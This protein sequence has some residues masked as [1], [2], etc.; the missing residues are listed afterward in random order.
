MAVEAAPAAS[1]TSTPPVP[2][3]AFSVAVTATVPASSPA[4]LLVASVVSVRVVGLGGRIVTVAS[5]AFAS[6]A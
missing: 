2:A 3:A 6:R 5:D 4:V 1:V